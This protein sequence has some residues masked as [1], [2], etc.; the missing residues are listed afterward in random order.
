MTARSVT[1]F[2]GVHA[3]NMYFPESLGAEFTEIFFV[4]IKGEHVE[5]R[6]P[7]DLRFVQRRMF[8][9]LRETRSL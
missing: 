5:V 4:G 1:K 7:S 6:S 3:L 2:Q 8:C 9:A